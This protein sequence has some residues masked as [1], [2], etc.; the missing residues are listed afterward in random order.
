MKKG[1]L[2]VAAVAA[3]A[4]VVGTGSPV[5]A[6]EKTLKIELISKGETHQFWQAV[7]KLI[8]SFYLKRISILKATKHTAFGQDQD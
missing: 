8:I 6:A 3:L 7:K 4:L 1:L 2:S 5:V